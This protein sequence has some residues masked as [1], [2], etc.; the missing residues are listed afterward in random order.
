MAIRPVEVE[1]VTQKY[2]VKRIALSIQY[3]GTDFCG[4]QRQKVGKSVQETL[5]KTIFSL[6]P[7]YPI[8]LI[9]AGRT[10]L[11]FHYQLQPRDQIA[12]ILLID[13]AGG[14]VSD[15]SGNKIELFSKGIVAAN[16]QIHTE[17]MAM[18]KGLDFRKT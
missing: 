5:E 6:E 11:Y 18:S 3:K 14:I 13:E 17:F 4:W 12:G 2:L 15:R 8:K 7:F 10:D 9:A 16:K 1:D